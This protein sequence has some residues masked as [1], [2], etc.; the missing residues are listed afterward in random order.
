MPK[1]ARELAETMTES[2]KA[3]AT[4]LTGGPKKKVPREPTDIMLAEMLAEAAKP[5][6][7]VHDEP[8]ILRAW[9]A[10]WDAAPGEAE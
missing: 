4:K 9:R 5:Q 2:V 7:T 6:I 3:A 1:T 10:A 8:A